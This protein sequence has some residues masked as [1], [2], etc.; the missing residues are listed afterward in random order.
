[1]MVMM[2]SWG[3]DFESCYQMNDYQFHYRVNT[4]LIYS[5]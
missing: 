2:V 3:R 5:F 1:M 4:F